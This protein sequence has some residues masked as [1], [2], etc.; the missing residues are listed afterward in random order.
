MPT[1]QH[2]IKQAIVQLSS[3]DARRLWRNNSGMAF[4]R[5]RPVRYGI[6]PG[7]GGPDIIG[8]WDGKFAAIEVKT[9]KANL[10]KEQLAFLML[11]KRLGGFAA[12]YTEQGLEEL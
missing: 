6:P 12:V 8:I 1:E 5:D 3:P 11:I 10:R 7:G 4:H 2:L 9:A